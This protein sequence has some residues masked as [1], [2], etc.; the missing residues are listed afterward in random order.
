MNNVF[1]HTKGT[2]VCHIS[3]L[4]R[5]YG[6]AAKTIHLNGRVL[7]FKQVPSK[8]TGKKQG[9]VRGEYQVG[10]TV[11][12]VELLL[13]N[14]KSGHA[15]RPEDVV[16]DT[17]AN[18]LS[19]PS[20]LNGSGSTADVSN[21]T[22]P[23]VAGSELSEDPSSQSS[24]EPTQDTQTTLPSPPP[25]APSVRRTLPFGYLPNTDPTR[26]GLPPVATS[27]G[28]NWFVDETVTQTS[29]NEPVSERR[30]FVKL[31]TGQRIGEGEGNPN[32]HSRL[33]YFMMMFPYRQLE[34]EVRWTNIQLHKARKQPTTAGELIKYKGI[35]LLATRFQFNSRSDLWSTTTQ[36]CRYIPAPYF[37]R[38]GMSRQWF[39]DL[40]SCLRCSLQPSQQLP[41]ETSETYRW[42]LVDDFVAHFNLHRYHTFVP[43]Q[44]LCADE[45]NS[46]LVR[47]RGTLDQ[48]WS[49]SVCRP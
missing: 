12:E 2:F 16:D 5:R 24:N 17:S 43:S 20:T 31:P 33:D 22:D 42:K 34:G 35:Q 49:A 18:I 6:S 32:L 9:F 21:I 38:T 47:P 48:L 15:A 36:W 13:R 14:V 26:N 1:F 37:G 10:S 3:E 7:E 23:T 46:L 45:S 11:K 8:K 28:T 19:P 39:D 44:M 4:S 30:W 25:F 40:T 41:G 29:I 27:H